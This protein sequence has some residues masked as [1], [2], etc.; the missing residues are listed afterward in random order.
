MSKLLVSDVMKVGKFAI[1]AQTV[2]GRA[3]QLGHSFACDDPKLVQT[4]KAIEARGE[5]DTARWFQ[6]R[7]LGSFRRMSK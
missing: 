4:I 5:I 7:A 3:W 2:D 6:I 1:Q